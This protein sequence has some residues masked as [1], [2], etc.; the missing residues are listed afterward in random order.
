MAVKLPSATD[1]AGY[2]NTRDVLLGFV[3]AV[4]GT[5]DWLTWLQGTFRLIAQCSISNPVR[6]TKNPTAK[7]SI[8]PILC[9][10]GSWICHS[11]FIGSTY[12]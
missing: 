6:T 9:F 10:L 1:L 11:V 7:T 4:V 8:I 5:T 12:T 2:Q 3:Y